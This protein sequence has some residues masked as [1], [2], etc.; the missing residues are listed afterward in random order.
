[1]IL[2]S[3]LHVFNH[4]FSGSTNSQSEIVS[5]DVHMKIDTIAWSPCRNFVMLALNSGQAQLVHLPSKVPLPP[6]S[7]LEG[8][9]KEGT[10]QT[11]AGCWIDES[12]N[13]KQHSLLLLSREG[14]VCLF[15]AFAYF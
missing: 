15:L 4:D 1:M 7:I 6:V 11:F 8:L 3:C 10:E 9:I 13:K 2:D 5:I 12:E 14:K